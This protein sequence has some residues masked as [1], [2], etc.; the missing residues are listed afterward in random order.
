MMKHW[1]IDSVLHRIEKYYDSWDLPAIALDTLSLIWALL[2]FLKFLV[3]PWH[4]PAWQAGKQTMDRKN[5]D[6]DTEVMRFWPLFHCSSIPAF[7]V[8]DIKPLT[9]KDAWFQYI[10]E[11][12]R[13][14][15]GLYIWMRNM[16]LKKSIVTR[17]C[18]ARHADFAGRFARYMVPRCARLTMPGAKCS[19]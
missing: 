12:P 18:D 14:L 10:I 16:N 4:Q 3:S 6:P 7:H 19:C 9:L 15:R 11:V 8:D 17:C 2:F 5:L 1:N 13:R